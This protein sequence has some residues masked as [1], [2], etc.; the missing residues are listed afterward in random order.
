M[1]INNLILCRI[2]FKMSVDSFFEDLQDCE[3]FNNKK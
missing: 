1:M 3:N 2:K